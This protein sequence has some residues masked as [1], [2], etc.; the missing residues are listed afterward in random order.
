MANFMVVVNPSCESNGGRN[1]KVEVLPRSDIVLATVGMTST[2]ESINS[3][4]RQSETV[5]EELTQG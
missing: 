3:G 2:M 4:T 5:A 1:S